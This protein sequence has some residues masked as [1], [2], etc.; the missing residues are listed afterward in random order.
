MKAH[1]RPVSAAGGGQLSCNSRAGQIKNPP[2]ECSGS[3]HGRHSYRMGLA[4]TTTAASGRCREELLG[5]RPA[6]RKCRP[7][8]ARMLG[9]A[10]RGTKQQPTGLI[11]YPAAQGRAVSGCGS[12][13]MLHALER[14]SHSAD[15]GPSFAS[16]YSPFCRYATSSPDQGKSLLA[17]GG[18]LSCNSRAG[19]IK[20]PPSECSGSYHIRHSYRM[21]LATT[22]TA[23]SGRCREELL[24]QRPARRTCRP[25]HARMLGA[26][27]WGTKKEPTGLF[28]AACGRPCSFDSSY[29]LHETAT[30]LDIPSRWD[31]RA[32]QS[33]TGALVAVLRTAALFDSRAG[34]IKNAL[35]HCAKAFL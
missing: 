32:N 22:T 31:P 30:T 9:A 20:N 3:Y 1:R 24:G 17:G 27:T 26:A 23:A 18:Q 14:R 28:F 16:L 5:Q 13:R 12:Q 11:A 6:R 2:S 10:T 25:R 34:Q 4:T 29:G 21:G 35:A 33:P 15:H 19:Q 7:R 8:H